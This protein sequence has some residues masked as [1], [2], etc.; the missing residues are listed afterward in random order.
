MLGGLVVRPSTHTQLLHIMVN[1][2]AVQR[3]LYIILLL[4]PIMGIH[5][6]I[7]IMGVITAE[8]IITADTHDTVRDTPDIGGGDVSGIQEEREL[9]MGILDQRADHW[10]KVCEEFVAQEFGNRIQ[11]RRTPDGA[12]VRTILGIADI[13]EWQGGVPWYDVQ[14][15]KWGVVVD[16]DIQ[17]TIHLDGSV[18]FGFWP[19]P[20]E[21]DLRCVMEFVVEHPREVSEL[22]SLLIRPAKSAQAK[23]E[24]LY[25]ERKLGELGEFRVLL[26]DGETWRI[27]D[28]SAMPAD[29]PDEF[30][31]SLHSNL[32][33]DFDHIFSGAGVE[34]C[35]FAERWPDFMK[36]LPVVSPQACAGYIL[37]AHGN[38]MTSAID[39]A[40]IPPDGGETVFNVLMIPDAQT[41][42]SMYLRQSIT[43]D[44]ALGEKIHQA[45]IV[46]GDLDEWIATIKAVP[47]RLPVEI[48]H[49]IRLAAEQNRIRKTL[50]KIADQVA[51]QRDA[52]STERNWHLA[53][54]LS[55]M[56][57]TDT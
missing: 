15:C 27:V 2:C 6:I 38:N 20:L 50:L 31:K 12:S 13:P 14:R 18:S 1:Q 16:T 48:R 51:C 8:I 34:V 3:R 32:A 4:R 30:R 22:F 33:L 37:D 21:D 19:P 42:S 11:F 54:T 7:P 28:P 26:P 53:H 40:D 23:E 9:I 29:T 44:K 52:Y 46:G 43:G 39:L 25:G 5:I 55:Q 57:D 47:V 35:H 41:V 24:C 49:Q 10:F 56:L 45:F 36:S 17:V